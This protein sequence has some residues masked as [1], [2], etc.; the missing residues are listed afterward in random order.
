MLKAIIVDDEY[1]SC[2]KM[3]K[4]LKESGL[5]EVADKFTEPLKALEFLKKTKMD[6]VFLDIEMP[7]MDGIELASRIMDIH[8][9]MAFV[10]VTAYNQY[11]VEAF[12]LNAIDYLLKPVYPERLMETLRRIIDQRGIDVNPGKLK[13]QCF[14]KFTVSDGSHKVILR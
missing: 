4:L 9:N 3:E 6:A 13:V 1:P 11:A 5:A 7:D 8:D 14:G 10:F 12:R 2:L